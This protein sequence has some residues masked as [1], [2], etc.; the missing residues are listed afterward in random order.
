[1][2]VPYGFEKRCPDDLRVRNL[3]FG[4]DEY[5]ERYKKD[6]L[7]YAGVQHN[8]IISL[9]EKKRKTIDASEFVENR[10]LSFFKDDIEMTN[11][12][13]G[14][15]VSGQIV[16]PGLEGMSFEPRL[17]D[18]VKGGIEFN[19]NDRGYLDERF[20]TLGGYFH[21]LF[22]TNGATVI[23]RIGN[24]GYKADVSKES[25]YNTLGHIVE[26]TKVIVANL[27]KLTERK[28][29]NPTKAI[30]DIVARVG[31]S[32]KLT[33]DIIE[34]YLVENDNTEYG[35]FNAVTRFANRPDLAANK[36]MELQ[37]LGGSLFAKEVSC[38][39]LCSSEII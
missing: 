18:V 4:K 5:L 37:R 20:L 1:M 3:N 22:C 14:N 23:E 32:N 25:L 30:R 6:R 7:L 38:C 31:G 34:A 39:A 24:I 12:S 8:Q 11:G 28:V 26:N 16:I 2:Q 33:E 9:E 29:A 19:L 21:R 36:R 17:N 13:L 35:I 15:I 10:I 27:H